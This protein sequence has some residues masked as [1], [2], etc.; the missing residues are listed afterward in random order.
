VGA[1]HQGRRSA[2]LGG[3]LEAAALGEVEGTH[4]AQHGGERA[5]TQAFLHRPQYVPVPPSA[6]KQEPAGIEPEG[7]E[8]GGVE[9][10]AR[11]APEDRTGRLLA[12][13]GQ[14]ESGEA[15][16]GAVA[17]PRR[18]DLVQPTESE[19]AAW[20]API[21]G[22][23]AERYCARAAGRGGR[24]FQNGDTP[25]QGGKSDGSGTGGHDAVATFSKN[26]LVLFYLSFLEGPGGSVKSAIQTR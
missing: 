18:R 9:G 22:A 5:G 12:H 16:G 23:N 3:E 13:A 25:A 26:V 19:P 6:G 10:I 11:C 4:L 21:D 20:Q 2:R 7:P 1:Q 8:A 15:G 14:Q 17:R 24:A